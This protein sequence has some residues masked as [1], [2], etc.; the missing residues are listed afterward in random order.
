[1]GNITTAG[2]EPLT[3]V[4]VVVTDSLTTLPIKDSDITF[5][6]RKSNIITKGRS[7]DRGSFT[8]IALPIGG[9]HIT[10][11]APGYNTQAL[12]SVFIKNLIKNKSSYKSGNIMEYFVRLLKN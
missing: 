6:N 5:T 12:N 9:I 1:M 10:I 11:T 8:S 4:K 3:Q 2:V 7:D